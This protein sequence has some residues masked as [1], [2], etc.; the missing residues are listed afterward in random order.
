MTTNT[1]FLEQTATLADT[2]LVSSTFYMYVQV[3]ELTYEI[4]KN[5]SPVESS[6]LRGHG[7]WNGSAAAKSTPITVVDGSKVTWTLDVNAN[8]GGDGAIYAI[9]SA[10]T[11]GA[12]DFSSWWDAWG[13]NI[14]DMTTTIAAADYTLI[15]AGNTYEVTLTR[16]GNLFT[17]VHKNATTNTVIATQSLKV[18][19]CPE[20]STFYVYVQFGEIDCSCAVPMKSMEISGANDKVV[21]GSTLQLS[22][23]VFPANTTDD[24]TI[25][26]SS[27]DNNIA[28]VDN[29]GK[30]TGVAEGNVTITAKVSDTI[31][32]T[33]EVAVQALA[34]PVTGIDVT[35]DKTEIKVGTTAQ[36]TTTVN[37]ADTTDDKTV[38]YTS[39]DENIATVDATGKVTAVKPGTVTITA[40][41]LDG[42]FT[43]TVEITVPVVAITDIELTV[44]KTALEKGDIV[45]VVATI[46][47]ADTTEDKTITWTSSNEKVATVDANGTV[48]AVGGGNATI[49]ATIGSVKA[50]VTFKVTAQ[51]TVV[52][53][54][55]IADFTVDAFLS[56]QS[57]GVQLKKGHTYTFTFNAKGTDAAST[58]LYEAP[59]YFIYTNS[60]NKFNTADYKELIFA[61]GDVWCWFNADT[62]QNPDALP[63]G[64]TFTR[65]FP[66]DWTAWTAAMKAGAECKLV[67]KYDG[68]TVT[69]TYT[70]ADASTVASF[71]VSIP[72]GSNLYLGLTGEKVELTD[73]TVADEYVTTISGKGDVLPVL[74][75]VLVLLGGAVVI[76]ASKKR[77]A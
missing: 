9:E 34:I 69:A 52:K 43:D 75:V 44:D 33:Y 66:E 51:E 18:T 68:S 73:I 31:V 71:P 14:T 36:L 53:K 49:T 67:V 32:D 62:A 13:A 74:P 27:S 63:D 50:E 40:S 30:V 28:T 46:N 48:T 19:D 41:V 35:T 11:N 4:T 15:Q 23:S 76:V 58:N 37:P 59:C 26:W 1:V 22:A 64:A 7:W 17:V 38:T 72:S 16:E 21:A 77:F 5:G 12:V 70:V 45:N 61:R 55:E 6:D 60:E 47:P 10:D 29:T 25:T 42:A 39:S 57:D 24:Y 20:S 65:T 56:V 2:S 8:I 3:G 54:S